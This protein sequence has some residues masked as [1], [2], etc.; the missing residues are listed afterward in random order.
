[1]ANQVTNK[2]NS[3]SANPVKFQ[4]I[5]LAIIATLL[6][7]ILIALTSASNAPLSV[8]ANATSEQQAPSTSTPSDAPQATSDEPNDLTT[9]ERCKLVLETTHGFAPKYCGNM[10]EDDPRLDSTYRA[11][12]DNKPDYINS[13]ICQQI[14]TIAENIDSIY[15]SDA[16]ETCTLANVTRY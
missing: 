4:A 10:A 14:K 2:L 5:T 7:A 13:D 16:L 3:T 1:M 8:N 12:E 6:F 11:I 15:I 9:L